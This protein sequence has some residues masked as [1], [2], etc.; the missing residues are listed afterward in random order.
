MRALVPGR[1]FADDASLN[2]TEEARKPGQR[3]GLG[4]GYHRDVIAAD[5]LL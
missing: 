2:L 1:Q 5:P 3:R 4:F